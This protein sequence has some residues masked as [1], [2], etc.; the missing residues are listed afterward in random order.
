MLREVQAGSVQQ[1]F[2][3][4]EGEQAVLSLPTLTAAP[5]IE[6]FPGFRPKLRGVDWME[7]IKPPRL[8]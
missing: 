1:A 6:L 3:P 2:L 8:E 4:R 5:A 7:I